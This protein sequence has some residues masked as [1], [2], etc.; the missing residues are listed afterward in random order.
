MSRVKRLSILGVAVILLLIIANIIVGSTKKEKTDNKT[1][2]IGVTMYSEF[3]PFTEEI[4]QN[5][6]NY[7]QVYSSNRQIEMDCTVVYAEEN[8]LVQNDQVEDF[9]D[10]GYD[11]VCVNLV[12][13]TDASVIIEKAKLADVPIIFFNRELVEDDLNRF[14]KLYYVGAR[15]EESG[16]LQ[17][18]LVREALKSRFDE[19]DISGDGVIQYVMLEGEAGHQDSIIRSHV[20]V[21][22]I[23]AGGIRLERLGDEIA[24]WDRQQAQTKITSL[25]QGYPRQIELIIAND[26]NM[27]LGAVDAL[28]AFGVQSMPLIVG[29]NGQ[30]EAI[31]LVGDG[32]ILG[33]VLN[34]S[35]EKGRAIARMALGLATEGSV[36]EDIKLVNDKYYYV[37]YKM[38]D[39]N[40]YSDYI[41]TT[42]GN[43]YP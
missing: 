4:K 38:I 17:G 23:L 29:V 22:T 33:T 14:D 7:L 26:D 18:L 25:L 13:R 3:D 37:P 24:N 15:P 40:N 36:P 28:R 19:I 39:R 31:Q 21:E 42:E 5:I 11:V 32:T 20:S 41:D 12:D 1:I 30:E 34:D 8:Q 43:T 35:C 2:K 16:K 6:Q 9:I 27:A 10:K